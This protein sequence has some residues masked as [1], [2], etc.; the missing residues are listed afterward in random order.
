MG[1]GV[2][3]ARPP[4]LFLQRLGFTAGLLGRWRCRVSWEMA[5]WG[6]STNWREGRSPP[7]PAGAEGGGWLAVM[8]VAVR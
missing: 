2:P 8:T 6:R 4:R 1:A 3:E 7:G 5:L